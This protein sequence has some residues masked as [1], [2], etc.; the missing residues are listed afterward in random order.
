MITMREKGLE[1]AVR[2]I[3]VSE[4]ALYEC[5]TKYPITGA[6]NYASSTSA[7][8][9]PDPG[10]EMGTVGENNTNATS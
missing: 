6:L 3:R 8:M 7:A 1:D 5:S 9:P 10:M 4:T 2:L